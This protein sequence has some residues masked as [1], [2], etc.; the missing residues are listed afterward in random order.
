MPSTIQLEQITLSTGETFVVEQG[1]LRRFL[2]ASAIKG[3]SI[4]VAKYDFWEAEPPKK[5][6]DDGSAFV[7]FVALLVIGLIVFAAL[8]H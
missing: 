1:K 5:D 3:G 6:P 2:Q 4:T 8:S 7:G